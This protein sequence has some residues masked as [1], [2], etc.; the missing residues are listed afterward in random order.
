M[1]LEKLI[2]QIFSSK[3]GKS[4]LKK[5]PDGFYRG[6][7]TFI[8]FTS[9]D[10]DYNHNHNQSCDY[11]RNHKFYYDCNIFYFYGL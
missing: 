1:E 7:Y 8:S 10:H 4:H 5:G 6:F 3:N 2:S 9:I 11:A